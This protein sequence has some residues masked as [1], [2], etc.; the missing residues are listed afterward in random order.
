MILFLLIPVYILIN[1]YLLHRIHRWLTAC[2]RKFHS[3]WFMIPYIAFYSLLALSLLLAFLLPASPLQ[4]FVKRVSN[5]WL[6]TFFFILLFV[7]AADLIRLIL[8]HIPGRI[9]N[10]F[11]SQ[12]GYV[13]TGILLT[14]CVIC[15][16]V[17][18]SVNARMIRTTSYKITLDKSC[19]SLQ[20]LKIAL[21]ADFHLGY[22][23]GNTQMKQVVKKINA[24]NPD[25]VLIAGDIFDNSYEAVQNP[26]AIAETLS[27][28]KSTYGTYGVFGN[29]DVTERLLGGFS[30]SSSQQELRDPRFQEFM[31]QA[32]IQILD[33]QVELIDHA[34]YLVGRMDASK[35][36]N[37][38]SGRLSPQT[39]LAGLDRE[40]PILILE[41]QPRQLEE[42]AQ[43]GADLQLCGHTHDGQIFPGNFLIRMFWE[44]PCGY[45]YK[46][47][48]HSIVT[49]GA[50]VWGPAMRLGTSGE[51]CEIT[52]TFR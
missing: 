35:P 41:H 24:M 43:E 1:L 2:S 21:A 18:G 27:Q 50:G 34:F 8:K 11:F 12:K 33:D 19:G 40:K 39:L 30:V 3:H 47:G 13:L 14:L 26:D 6:G 10:F 52:V 7:A 45:L 22:S 49:S 23:V 37:G 42:L 28:L 38:S 17:Y 32:G 46:N 25:I 31:N 36:G 15:C 29:H 16:S 48:L 4:V 51:V 20:Q 5:Y 44:N 9:H